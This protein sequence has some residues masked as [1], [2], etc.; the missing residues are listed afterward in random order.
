MHRASR[1]VGSLV[2]GCSVFP[3]LAGPASIP[4]DPDF[5]YQWALLNTGQTVNDQI[6]TAGADIRALPAW[7]IYPGSSSIVV[8]IVDTGVDPHPEFADRLLEGYVAPSAG[9]DPYS[10]LDTASHGTHVAGIIGAAT[11]NGVGIAGIN[12]KAWL[13]PVRVFQGNLGTEASTAEGIV[14]AVDHGANVIVVPLQFDDGTQVLADAVAYAAERDVVVVAPAGQTAS[15][16]VAFPAAFDGCIAVSSTTNTDILATFS[17]Y[18]PQVDLSAPS[19]DIWSTR[20]GGAY[21]FETRA[22]SASAAAHVAGVASLIRSYAPQLTAVE[23]RRILTDSADDLGDPGWDPKF[24]AGRINAGRALELTPLPALRFEY[25]DPLPTTIQPDT[26]TT[27]SIRIAD[28]AQRVVPTSAA[29]SYRTATAGFAAPSPLRPLGGGLFEVELPAAP[30]E[31]TIEYYLSATGDGGGVVTDPL[32]APANLHTTRAIRY[33]ALFDDDFDSDLGWETVTEG[34]GTTGAWTRAIPVGTSA[35]PAYDYSTD[36]GRYC[37]VTGQHFGGDNPGSNDVDGG[38]V[39]L[40]SPV[41]PLPAGDAEV[42]YSRWFYTYTA[43]EPPDM[44]TVE[45]SRDGGA[46]WVVVETVNTAQGWTTYS[47]RL[48]EFPDAVGNQLRIR[49]TT[50]DILFPGDSLTEAAVDEFH[51]RA[52]ECSSVRGDADGDGD[53][54]LADLARLPG[55]WKGPITAFDDPA[56]GPFDFDSDRHI[57]L[58][59]FRGLQNQFRP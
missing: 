45:M 38:P 17:N 15:P 13:L 28:A 4:N 21:G 18:G 29:L 25:V 56:C 33:Q 3:S 48:S 32:D 7:D 43:P 34:A 24:G 30:C 52:I 53:V 40:I 8:A 50:S 5:V 1:A 42:A 55:C 22:G 35:Q 37:F 20:S 14:W 39:R 41:I 6:G 46:S 57:D 19:Q 10:T 12:D 54:D 27:F 47:F 9:G 11:G 2:L 16:E 51:V 26:P 23:V 58:R 36:Y 44:L 49:F 31:T 59:D